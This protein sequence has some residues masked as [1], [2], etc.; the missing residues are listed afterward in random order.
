MEVWEMVKELTENHEKK[1]IAYSI[2]D[3]TDKI[4]ICVRNGD[5]IFEKE[6]MGILA[7]VSLNIFCEEVREPVSFAEAIES[8]KRIKVIHEFTK[9]DGCDRY[10][11]LSNLL[12]KLS[13][14]SSYDI[15][16]IILN[17]EF[18]IE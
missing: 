12:L 9:K 11:T 15:R 10:M 13:Q 18:Y 6:G 16:D 7:M 8:G 4:S 14:Y 5:I 1:F 2:Y 3:N 17:G